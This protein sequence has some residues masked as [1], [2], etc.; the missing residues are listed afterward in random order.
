MDCMELPLTYGE[1]GDRD[2]ETGT[3]NGS[4]AIQLI[5]WMKWFLPHVDSS[6]QKKPTKLLLHGSLQ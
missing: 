2:R 3:V 4:S 6:D 5:R 1:G